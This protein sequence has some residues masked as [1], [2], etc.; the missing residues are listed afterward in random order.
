MFIKMPLILALSGYHNV[1]K[2]TLACY[3][4][5]NLMPRGFK[6]GVIK[7]TKEE[8]EL[9][10]REGTDT[11]RY[12]VAGASQVMLFQKERATLY[13]SSLP[14]DRGR[15]LTFLRNLFFDH[16]LLLLEGFKTWDEIPKIWVKGSKEEEIPK[17]VLNIV[18][19]ATIEEKEDILHFVETYLQKEREHFE[20][21]L[22]VN[23]KEIYLKPHLQKL[24]RHLLLGLLATLKDIPERIFSIQLKIK[25]KLGKELDK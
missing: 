21:F 1:G 22:S 14:S 10:D 8:K 19:S 13:L 18:F 7:S 11:F 24:C 15:L 4:I 17:E 5:E 9:T 6:V 25:E 3:L 23:G 20:V 16:D 2:T 12:K